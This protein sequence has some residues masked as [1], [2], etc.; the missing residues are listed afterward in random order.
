MSLCPCA[1][2]FL[3]WQG[4]GSMTC[5]KIFLLDL[6]HLHRPLFFLP[7]PF[8]LACHCSHHFY[9]HNL[10]CGVPEEGV[11]TLCINPFKTGHKVRKSPQIIAI[12]HEYAHTFVFLYA[13]DTITWNSRAKHLTETRVCLSVF[14][15]E[16]YISILS[17]YLEERKEGTGRE[18]TGTCGC[19]HILALVTAWVGVQPIG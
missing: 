6:N 17:Y 11:A 8:S 3:G 1:Y 9:K 19:V 12:L 13:Q 14:V 2:H 7:H 5:F 15:I 18:G 10:A 16:L 4:T